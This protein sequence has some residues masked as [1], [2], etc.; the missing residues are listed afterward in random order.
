MDPFLTEPDETSWHSVGGAHDLYAYPLNV[1]L[2]RCWSAG[3]SGD[4]SSMCSTINARCNISCS[5]TTSAINECTAICETVL[6]GYIMA[7]NKKDIRSSDVH[8]RPISIISCAST[9]VWA[10]PSSEASINPD[11]SSPNN[12]WTISKLW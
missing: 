10:I 7:G 5:D 6:C 8:I 9:C 4:G 3:G 12:L 1:E 11:S 2:H